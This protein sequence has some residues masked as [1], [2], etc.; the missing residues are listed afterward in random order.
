MQKFKVS[1]VDYA[2]DP[3]KTILME[4]NIWAILKSKPESFSHRDSEVVASFQENWNYKTKITTEVQETYNCFIQTIHLAFDE[5]RPLS[6][7]PDHFWTMIAQGLAIHIGENSEQLKHHFVQFEGKK[8]LEVQ[9]NS[10]VKG[11]MD[12]DWQGCFPEFSDKLAEFIGKKRDLIVANFSTTGPIEKTISEIVL[13]DSMKS[14]FD[15]GG[16]TM[17]GIPEITLE[18]TVE[19]YKNIRQRVQA[20]DE[21]GLEWWTKKLIPVVDELIKTASGNPDKEFWKSF[22]HLCGGSGGPYISGWVNNF[23]PYLY[24]SYNNRFYINITVSEGRE[25]QG[26]GPTHDALPSGLS[27]V[28]FKWFYYDQIFEMEFIGG[29]TW[30]SQNG[31]T[32]RP[33]LGWAVKEGWPI[34]SKSEE[35]T[36][37]KIIKMSSKIS[38]SKESFDRMNQIRKGH[39]EYLIREGMP[40]VTIMCLLCRMMW[41]NT[42]QENHKPDC[43]YIPMI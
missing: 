10:F 5:H 12:N 34:V 20:F 32:L 4:E 33:E 30:I 2:S 14:Y 41:K 26:G 17:C 16:K 22:Y 28:P 31:F 40:G 25:G 23:I 3:L 35:E 21:F 24:S 7:S 29:F 37:A 42:K 38:I 36:V 1:N 27:K 13:M 8:Y 39:F 18:G 6:L 43:Q 15:Y 19:D 9:R 11:S